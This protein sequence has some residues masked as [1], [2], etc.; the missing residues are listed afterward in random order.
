[1]ATTALHSGMPEI[2]RQGRASPYVTPT[3]RQRETFQVTTCKQQL[4][5]QIEENKKLRRALDLVQ[6]SCRYWAK[7]AV[8]ADTMIKEAEEAR[9]FWL[10]EA[11]DR[12]TR[13]VGCGDNDL[14]KGE[15]VCST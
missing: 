11:L 3:M 13:G 8:E 10:G 1:M 2:C 6:E 9:D 7:R 15:S 5:H 14:S 12:Q 4:E